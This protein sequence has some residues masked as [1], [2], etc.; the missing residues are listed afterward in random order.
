MTAPRTVIS[1]RAKPLEKKKKKNLDFLEQRV[2]REDEKDNLHPSG[3]LFE[4]FPELEEVIPDLGTKIEKWPPTRFIGKRNP[5]MAS[6]GK[7]V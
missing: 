6:E 2:S 7:A 1:T 5:Q 4:F 3:C